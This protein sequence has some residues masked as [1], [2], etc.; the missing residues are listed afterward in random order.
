MLKYIYLIMMQILILKNQ[1]YMVQLQ[2]WVHTT[3]KNKKEKY[4]QLR[5]IK[6]QKR[7][8]FGVVVQIINLILPRKIQFVNIYVL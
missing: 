5:Y 3:Q 7:E 2:F 8:H 6:N 1:I 4:I